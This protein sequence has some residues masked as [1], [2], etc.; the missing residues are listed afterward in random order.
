M[1]K[2]FTDSAERLTVTGFPDGRLDAG[3]GATLV[4][5]DTQTGVVR[6]LLV[7][8][9]ADARA[10]EIT[11]DGVDSTPGQLFVFDASADPADSLRTVQSPGATFTLPGRSV[12]VAEF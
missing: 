11:L 6:V 10:V 1:A 5:Q 12:A 8:R 4:A 9:N 7:N 3:M 2:L